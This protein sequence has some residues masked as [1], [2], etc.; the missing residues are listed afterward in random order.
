MRGRSISQAYLQT[1][2]ELD[3][4]PKPE[5][6][7]VVWGTTPKF[8]W[9]WSSVPARRLSPRYGEKVVTALGRC[10]DPASVD[11]VT[12]PGGGYAPHVT[13]SPIVGPLLCGL[14][15]S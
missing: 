4:I 10:V 14:L 12:F 13:A 7:L 11:M 2:P 6:S 1:D 8:A 5:R 3:G 15:T 9:P